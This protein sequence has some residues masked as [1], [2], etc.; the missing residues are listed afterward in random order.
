LE[1]ARL[2]VTAP[3]SAK[4]LQRLLQA[5][6]WLYLQQRRRSASYFSLSCKGFPL[7]ACICRVYERASRGQAKA[8]SRGTQEVQL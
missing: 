2:E 4:L 7:R 1:G 8:G 6:V 3:A 5:S